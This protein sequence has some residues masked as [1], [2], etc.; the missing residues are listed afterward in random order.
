[1]GTFVP[2]L[3]HRGFRRDKSDSSFSVLRIEFVK[4]VA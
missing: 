2:Q 3:E 1:M 4:S